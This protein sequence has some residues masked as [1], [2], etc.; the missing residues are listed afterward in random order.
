MPQLIVRHRLQ[1]LQL[2]LF[3]NGSHES[4]A[5]TVIEE[6]LDQSSYSV[7][8]LY[9]ITRTLLLLDRIFEIFFRSQLISHV[10]KKPKREVSHDPEKAGEIFGNLFRV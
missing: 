8:G 2:F 7:L 4:E 5:V 6:M 9:L 10:I 1:T 3:F